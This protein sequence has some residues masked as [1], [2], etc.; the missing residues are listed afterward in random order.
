MGSG[1]SGRG[2]RTIALTA[3]KCGASAEPSIRAANIQHYFN[4]PL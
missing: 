4:V 2:S 3:L 1:G